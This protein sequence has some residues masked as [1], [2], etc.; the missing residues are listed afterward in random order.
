MKK[1]NILL[2]ITLSVILLLASLFL[3]SCNEKKQEVN[4]SKLSPDIYP[5]S[6]VEYEYNDDGLPT[7]ATVYKGEKVF[8]KYEYVYGED[9]ILEKRLEKNS[10]DILLCEYEYENGKTLAYKTV[11]S[12]DG[13]IEK[14]LK[15]DSEGL[16]T[17]RTNYNVDGNEELK[18]DYAEDGKV[19]LTTE[20]QYYDD[21][22]LSEITKTGEQG[23]AEELCY[24]SNGILTEEY[25]Y[26]YDLYDGIEIHK[27]TEYDDNGNFETRVESRYNVT[28]NEY[29][30]SVKVYNEDDI[31]IYYKVYDGKALVRYVEYDE[32][33][34]ETLLKCF[35][36]Y[37]LIHYV[38]YDSGKT[39]S[40]TEYEYDEN[41]KITG[42]TEHPVEGKYII[43]DGNDAEI[44][45]YDVE[46]NETEHESIDYEEWDSADVYS[47]AR[48]YFYIKDIFFEEGAIVPVDDLMLYF[49]LFE[50]WDNNKAG[51]VYD[52]LE[53]YRTNN[54]EHIYE[55]SIPKE[56]VNSEIEKHFAVKVDG[57]ESEYTNPENEDH[58]LIFPNIGGDFCVAMKDHTVN[59]NRS[60]ATYA[61]YDDLT[62]WIYRKAEICIENEDSEEEFKIIY[63]REVE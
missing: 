23:I 43:P 53:Q 22:T 10:K 51:G 9:G 33:G 13:I 55:I 48:K 14:K 12:D 32:S 4:T 36:E 3:F 45:M 17:Q 38:L 57:A 47:S 5:A 25:K 54:E 30:L 16:V 27:Y 31:P 26:T 41:G 15:Y 42:R 56:I 39:V 29:P 37:G 28:D 40:W 59:G 11:Y 19:F 20:Y 6:N 60:T 63:V 49:L 24:N 18:I 7:G 2:L 8:C 52:Y 1:R 50:V 21:G 62:G 34:K 44:Y 58:Y 61:C 35:N 46:E